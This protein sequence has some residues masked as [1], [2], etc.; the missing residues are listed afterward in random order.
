MWAST[1][2]NLG[3]AL[4]RLGEREDGRVNWE[5]AVRAYR[6]ALKVHTRER[7]PLFWARVQSNLGN[8]LVRLGELDSDTIRAKTASRLTGMP[9]RS[10]PANG[11]AGLGR[12]AEQSRDG[13]YFLGGVKVSPR[14]CRGRGSPSSRA[15][16]TD[17]RSGPFAWAIGQSNL[18]QALS[19]LG[20]PRLG[21]GIWR[22]RRVLS[23]R[24]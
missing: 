11:A 15:Q 20:H 9:W 12:D 5:A 4:M 1:Q 24:R 23:A 10:K 16:R 8:T 7:V 19:S 21:P 13:A 14:R 18:G 22:L 3:L 2:N 6:E 17:P